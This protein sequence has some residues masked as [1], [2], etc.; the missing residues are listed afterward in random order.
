[1]MDS[2]MMGQTKVFKITGENFSF[3]QNEIRVKKGDRVKINFESVG[4]FHD[5][6]VAEFNA[7][8]MRVN[9]GGKT[10][11]EFFANKAGEFEY[12]CSVG[13]HRQMGMKGKLIVE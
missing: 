3:S 10:S 6:T 8:T 2:G 11:V 12:Y 7:R 5:W 9:T 4:G 1:M 13:Q